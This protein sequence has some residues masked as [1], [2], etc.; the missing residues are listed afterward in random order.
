MDSGYDLYK[1][2]PNDRLLWI[3][4][5]QELDKARRLVAA[6]KSTSMD[7][8]L[9][10]DFRERTVV[11]IGSRVLKFVRT[12]L[13]GHAALAD[14]ANGA[15]RST[16]Q[17]SGLTKWMR[18]VWC[19]RKVVPSILQILDSERGSNVWLRTNRKFSGNSLGDLDYASLV[20]VGHS[21]PEVPGWHSI[22]S[23]V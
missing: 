21:E 1:R 9:V 6:M 17:I 2:L 18:S 10:Y 3:E 12:D 19:L 13:V 22:H 7:D 23:S 5:V 16:R 4:R 14:K 11:E 15:L 20:R 8:F